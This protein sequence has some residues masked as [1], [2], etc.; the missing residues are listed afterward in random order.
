MKSRDR[1]HRI[2]LRIEPF[3]SVFALL[4]IPALLLESRAQSP[5][6]RLMAHAIN[7]IVWLAFIA[8][9]ALFF[10]SAPGWRTVR[11]RWLDVAII[12]ISP[13]M[14]VPD[15]LQSARG[16]RVLRL[17]RL[18][19]VARVGLLLTRGLSDSRR[20]FRHRK[21]HFVVLVAVV[22]VALGALGVFLVEGDQNPSVSS[23][24]NAL[25][26]SVVTA[27]TVGYGDVSPVTTEGR[28]IAVVLMLTGI[29]VIG[30]FTAT[31]AS[32]FLEQDS[33]APA[34]DVSDRLAALERKVDELLARSEDRKSDGIR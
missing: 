8:E 32:F 29:G 1:A 2:A 27:T 28:L 16:L 3:V 14:L 12:L 34:S 22:V 6:I 21:F 7:W 23:F 4:V 13:P 20:A 11:E 18:F 25:W 17:F 10:A 33:A 26:W 31:V 19:R 15:Y 9:F 30:V 24:G 5:E